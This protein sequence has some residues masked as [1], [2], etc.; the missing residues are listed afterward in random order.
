MGFPAP[1]APVATIPLRRRPGR[2]RAAWLTVELREGLTRVDT[3]AAEDNKALVRRLY[4]AIDEGD[5]AGADDLIAADLVDHGSLPGFGPGGEGFKQFFALWRAAFPDS[6][7]TVEDLIAEGDRVAARVTVWGT[8]SGPFVGL[9]PTGK[10][11]VVT[12]IVISRISAGKIVELWEETDDLGLLRQL[13]VR[14]VSAGNPGPPGSGPGRAQDLSE[15]RSVTASP[16]EPPQWSGAPG[17]ALGRYADRWMAAV[18]CALA[19]VLVGVIYGLWPALAIVLATGVAFHAGR[20]RQRAGH[21]RAPK[22][23]AAATPDPS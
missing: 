12:G 23:S 4:A 15:R 5:L 16:A 9:A 19:A 2:G 6:R 7:F 21:R 3:M 13:G 14:T 22:D 18:F 20:D 17:V 11:V 1:P 10:R 8:H